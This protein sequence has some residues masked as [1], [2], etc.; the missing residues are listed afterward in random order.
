MTPLSHPGQRSVGLVLAA[1]VLLILDPTQAGVTHELALPLL[2][3]V[4]AWLMTRSLMAVL[5]AACALFA[6]NADWGGNDPIPSIAYPLLA[7]SSL[8]G[9]LVIIGLRWREK[10]KATHDERWARRRQT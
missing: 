10:V 6:L 9:C 5:I 8:A 4:A 1:A 2:L 3:A 7:L